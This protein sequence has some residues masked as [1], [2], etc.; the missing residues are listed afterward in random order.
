MDTME[1]ILAEEIEGL[2][3]VYIACPGKWKMTVQCNANK[4]R[5]LMLDWVIGEEMRRRLHDN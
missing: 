3:I 2:D 5:A 1:A 4:I